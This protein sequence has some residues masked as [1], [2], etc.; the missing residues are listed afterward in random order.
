MAM[1]LF[2][3][4]SAS[5]NWCWWNA[6]STARRVEKDPGLFGREKKTCARSGH[7]RRR[8]ASTPRHRTITHVTAGPAKAGAVSGAD[9]MPSK[10]RTGLAGFGRRAVAATTEHR[11]RVCRRNIAGMRC[12]G[13]GQDSGQCLQADT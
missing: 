11:R 7:A 9:T 8:H 12:R 2:T 5:E 10:G 13:S 3:S 1:N 6:S 4:L